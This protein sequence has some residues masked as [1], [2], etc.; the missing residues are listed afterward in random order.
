MLRSPAR[1][2]IA[3]FAL[4]ACLALAACAYDWGVPS[5]ADAG[6]TDAAFA[7]AGRADATAIDATTADGSADAPVTTADA[8]SDRN[9]P[10]CLALFRHVDD[11]RAAAKKC[12]SSPTACTTHIF[13]QCNCVTVVGQSSTVEDS[14]YISAVADLRSSGCPLACPSSCPAARDGLCVIFNGGPATACNQ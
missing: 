11:T 9:P 13:D 1:A 3:P 14:A 8:S 4:A 5:T 7:D 6:A 10:D 2:A 12:I